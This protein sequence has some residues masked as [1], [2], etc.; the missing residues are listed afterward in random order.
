M[1]KES[2]NRKEAVLPMAEKRPSGTG[3]KKEA[4]ASAN[5]KFSG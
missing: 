1:A 5:G 2:G 3:T 4:P